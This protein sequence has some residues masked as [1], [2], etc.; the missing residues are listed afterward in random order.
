MFG[1]K[2]DRYQKKMPITKYTSRR[3]QRIITSAQ[4]ANRKALDL[5]SSGLAF[6]MF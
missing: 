5:S 6:L 4:K 1:A 2:H 3:T